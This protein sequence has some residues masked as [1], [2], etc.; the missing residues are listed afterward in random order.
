MLFTTYFQIAKLSENTNNLTEAL[1]IS[2]QRLKRATYQY[3]YGQSTK[4]ELLNA[5]VDI[6]NDSITLINA[7]QQ[8]NNV[9]RSLNVILGVEKN[10]N[11]EVET[12]VVFNKMLNFKDLHKKTI[13]NN[14][15]LKQNEK[16]NESSLTGFD[17]FRSHTKVSQV[18]ST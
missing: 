5:E 8:L 1:A 13:A 18:L 16:N 14:V 6:N 2:K 10:I 9:K 11:F 4:L 17:K 7:K 15:T 12:K 3:E